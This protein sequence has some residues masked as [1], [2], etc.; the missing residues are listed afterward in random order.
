MNDSNPSGRRRKS[1][2][3]VS[4]FR[5]RS[6]SRDPVS[7]KVTRQTYFRREK[8]VGG[9][10]TKT[11]NKW[12]PITDPPKA[13]PIG[14][15]LGVLSPQ[16]IYNTKRVTSNKLG[17][18]PGQLYSLDMGAYQT[19]QR[20]HTCKQDNYR[21]PGHF[22][23]LKL[24]QPIINPKF[25]QLMGWVVQSICLNCS[26]PL[27]LNVE[28]LV[29]Q[30]PVGVGWDRL[31]AFAESSA[32]KKV[33]PHSDCGSM[34]IKIKTNANGQLEVASNL[35]V[36]KGDAKKP[37]KPKTVPITIYILEERLSRITREDLE[38]IGFSN[39]ALRDQIINSPEI[40]EMWRSEDDIIFPNEIVAIE[41][42]SPLNPRPE[43]LIIRY[44]PVLPT[45]CRPPGYSE[46]FSHTPDAITDAYRGVVKCNKATP[47]GS[48]APLVSA[49]RQLFD[50]KGKVVNR[51]IRGAN[52]ENSSIER[53]L[54]GKGGIVRANLLG[55]RT[56]YN[57]RGVVTPDPYIDIDCVVLP[58][59]I[60][61]RLTRAIKVFSWNIKKCQ[62]WMDTNQVLHI[63]KYSGGPQLDT[64][65]IRG[66]SRKLRIGNTIERI[67]Q[68]G[69]KII[70]NRQP[71]LHK[72]SMMVHTVIA[73]Q[74][75]EEGNSI[76]FNP[77]VCSPYNADQL[78]KE[79]LH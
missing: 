23:S 24:D 38:F 22:G 8:L 72:G 2:K 6:S 26:R 59:Y 70:F 64:K 5:D 36:K 4:D 52:A 21:C 51:R 46:Q 33:C 58:W 67:L 14:I 35:P 31:K 39:R 42:D 12:N 29:C 61:S 66:D 63:R 45:C 17:N 47:N 74:S 65:Y 75:D 43:W 79:S 27:L 18:G 20:C 13:V 37:G 50:G 28:N 71:T 77:M 34:V 7:D 9:V 62:E 30:L 1:G 49:V 54:K 3:Y 73:L 10:N 16:E 44:L 78:L 56:D 25:L 41:N 69:D 60:V 32:K 76:S 40:Q 68:T 57:A 48:H 19:G 55:K 15:T 11:S 53:R